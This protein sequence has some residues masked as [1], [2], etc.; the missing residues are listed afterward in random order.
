M[1]ND[2]EILAWIEEWVSK[3]GKLPSPYHLRTTHGVG[4]YRAVR[5]IKQ[6]RQSI[7]KEPEH[8]IK[9]AGVDKEEYQVEKILINKWGVPGSENRQIKVWLN[10]TKEERALIEALQERLEE[11]PLITRPEAKRPDSC[12]AVVSVPDLHVGMLAWG[13]ETG[14]SYDTHIAIA[15]MQSSVANLLSRISASQLPVEQIVFPI[16]NDILHSD[17]H[18]N[19]TAAGTKLDVDSRWQKAFIEIADALI[20][21]PLAWASEIAPLR[22]VIVP[23]NHDYQRAFYLG[24]VISWYFKGRNRQVEV[25]NSPRLRKYLLWGKSL[26]GFT[27]GS[28]LNIKDLPMIMA[29]EAAGA[30]G[31][32]VWRE[33]IIGHFHRKKE[34]VWNGVQELGGVRVRILPSMAAA[35]SWHYKQGYVGGVKE[36]TATLYTANG[37]YV[38][39]YER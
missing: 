38:D 19:T 39:L 26:L 8:F 11:Q 23:G 1:P 37:P 18:E 15:K 2:Q 29:Q 21:G 16:G 34:M 7:F 5:L 28:W 32:S 25:D 36:A 33:W 30:W 31:D 20:S 12:M 24:E 4:E 6:F 17:T 3:N 10:K 13:K 27:H 22:V 14:E 9:E 35:D